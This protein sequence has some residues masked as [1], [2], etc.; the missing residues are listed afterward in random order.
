MHSFDKLIKAKPKDLDLN[1]PV[2]YLDSGTGVWCW[3]AKSASRYFYPLPVQRYRYNKELPGTKCYNKLLNSM[4]K[5]NGKYM[6]I[7][8]GWFKVPKLKDFDAFRKKMKNYK[9]Y[10]V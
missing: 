9:K 10:S 3:G 2:L 4:N 7:S 5:F 8:E 6:L 1:K